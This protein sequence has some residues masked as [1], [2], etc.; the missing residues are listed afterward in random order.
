MSMSEFMGWS[1]YFKQNQEPTPEP[2]PDWG[3]K[4]TIASVFNL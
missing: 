4:K 1:Q 2:A 3:D